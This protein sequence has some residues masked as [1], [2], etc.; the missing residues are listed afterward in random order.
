MK[1]SKDKKKKLNE[2]RDKHSKEEKLVD[3]L[4][5][6]ALNK[7]KTFAAIKEVEGVLDEELLDNI[8]ETLKIGLERL[9]ALKET[10][11]NDIEEFDFLKVEYTDKKMRRFE[12]SIETYEGILGRI[13]DRDG[14][15]FK[16]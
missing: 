8:A 13:E 2:L 3:S 7:L 1:L 11:K 14:E 16:L 6:E 12:E 10:Y 5:K 4:I 9:Y 15:L